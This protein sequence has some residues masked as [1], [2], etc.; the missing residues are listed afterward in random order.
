MKASTLTATALTAA[1][2][3]MAT[4]SGAGQGLQFK[5]EYEDNDDLFGGIDGLNAVG[6]VALSPDGT[7][8][9]AV[10]SLEDSIAAF[11]R[12]PVSGEL[13]FVTAYFD[14]D[15]SSPHA[16][17]VNLGLNSTR[18]VVVS[19]DSRHVYA[20]GLLDRAVG[21]FS[22][23]AATSALT[24]VEVE[25]DPVNL[26]GAYGIAVSP[27]DAHVYVA[28]RSA[29]SV[30]AFSR[31]SG[32][33]ALSFLEAETNGAGGVTGLNSAVRVRDTVTL[34]GAEARFVWVRVTRLAGP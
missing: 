1:I 34:T 17:A 16:G 23:V 4:G 25:A 14:D 21:V 28:S 22:R 3:V 12:D 5:A 29:D 27:D 33:G 9:Y 7:S 13:S 20:T 10:G 2:L 24:L 11:S 15:S 31:N 19:R 26:S 8:L 30:T 32:S 18:D 6:S